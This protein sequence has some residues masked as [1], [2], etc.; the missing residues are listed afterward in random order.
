M[1][2][3]KER[4]GDI[5]MKN[6]TGVIMIAIAAI[7]LSSCG[8]GDRD[9]ETVETLPYYRTE[10]LIPEWPDNRKDGEFVSEMHSIGNFELLNQN[11]QKLSNK[12]MEGKIYVVDFFFTTCPGICPKMTYNMKKLQDRFEY[13]DNINFLSF[14]VMPDVDSVEVMK[15]YAVQ[16]GVTDGKWNLLTGDRKEIYLLA[17]E[18]FFAD[19]DPGNAE[20]FLHS[21][22]FFLV[23]GKG[24]I[25]GI[26]NGTVDLEVKKVIED[27]NMLEG[28]QA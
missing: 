6:S 5:V 19:V 9:V 21:E 28:E 27:I 22:K 13:N 12:D 1:L 10:A 15:E 18:S 17:R 26:Y 25:R 24:N 23:D 14:S 16:Y 2:Y 20:D 4:R 3:S 8:K 11:G 7:L